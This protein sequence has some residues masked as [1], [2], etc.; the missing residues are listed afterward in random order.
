MEEETIDTF[1]L[2]DWAENWF[3]GIYNI[4]EKK[5]TSLEKEAQPLGLDIKKRKAPKTLK[6][7]NVCENIVENVFAASKKC[8]NKNCNGTLSKHIKCEKVLKRSPPLTKKEC[9]V[10]FKIMENVP[11]ATKKCLICSS[12]LKSVKCNI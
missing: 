8:P 2:P 12:M 6:V 4:N 10:C 3:A 7:C 1:C 5:D 9:T 11:T